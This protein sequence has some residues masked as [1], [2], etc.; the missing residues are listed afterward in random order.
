MPGVKKQSKDII[1]HLVMP[2][3]DATKTTKLR[4][5]S[6]NELKHKRTNTEKKHF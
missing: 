6:T 2:K 5:L 1:S 3:Q 4:G